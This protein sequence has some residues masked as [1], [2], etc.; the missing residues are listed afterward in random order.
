MLGLIL[1]RGEPLPQHFTHGHG[2]TPEQA[3]L[4]AELVDYVQPDRGRAQVQVFDQ[5][6]RKEQELEVE[7]ELELERKHAR[8]RALVDR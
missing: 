5:A 1:A 7:L 2:K 4:Q 8:V 3:R 6:R